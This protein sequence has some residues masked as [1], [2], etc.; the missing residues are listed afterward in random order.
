[1]K[2]FLYCVTV[3]QLNKPLWVYI[4]KMLSEKEEAYISFW[5]A[6][7]EKQKKNV[8]QFVVGL[9]IGLTIGVATFFLILSGW[10]ERANMVANSRLSPLIFTIIIVAIAVFMAYIYR[11]YQWE[12]REQQYLELLA[13][14][15]KNANLQNAMQQ[16]SL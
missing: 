1:M 4:C 3:H 10:Y 11:N 9:S 13:K 16:N 15:K 7:R 8:K 2:I 14:K 5:E 12:M 6:N